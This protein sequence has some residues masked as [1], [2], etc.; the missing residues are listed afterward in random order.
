MKSGTGDPFGPMD[1]AAGERRWTK[2]PNYLSS[3]CYLA[4]VSA[5]L[6][7]NLVLAVLLIS[8][9]KHSNHSPVECRPNINQEHLPTQNGSTNCQLL[10]SQPIIDHNARPDPVASSD[11]SALVLAYGFLQVMDGE[12][13]GGKTGYVSLQNLRSVRYGLV[14]KQEISGSIATTQLVLDYDCARLSFDLSYEN[15]TN[16]Y[17]IN[18]FKVELKSQINTERHREVVTKITKLSPVG[19]GFGAAKR[20]ACLHP[21]TLNGYSLHRDVERDLI[22][23]GRTTEV[24][25]ARLEIELFGDPDHIERGF[26]SREKD[27]LRCAGNQ[28]YSTLASG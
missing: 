20:L 26:F 3:T 4:L 27:I 14:Q 12:Q 22:T 13:T 11:M 1:A 10:S 28:I 17:E 9:S 18:S 16:Y 6:V 7:V 15:V 23:Q 25:L 19:L 8:V 2:W 21:V 24:V 5:L